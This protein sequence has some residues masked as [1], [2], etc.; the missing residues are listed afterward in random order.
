MKT[1]WILLLFSFS[2]LS[3][4]QDFPSKP[5]RIVVPWPPGGNVDITA[6]TV[7]AALGDALG[8]QVIVDNRPGASGLIGSGAVA[9]SP[10]DGY[11]LLLGSTGTIT[12]AP[13]VHK[14][15]AYDP[16]RDFTAIGGIQVTPMVV[17]A[18]LRT[19][20]QSYSD[21][22]ALAKTRSVSMATPG[23]ATTNHL[24]L[25]LLMRQANLQFLH[26]PYKGAGPAITD[27][28]GGQVDAMI[29]QLSASIGHI[30]EGRFK[31]LAVTSKTR[32][33]QLPNVPT[34]H[35]LGV[36]DFEVAT[37]T[38]IF[39][40]GD[41]P[42]PVVARLN[43]ALKKALAMDSVR[44]KYRSMGVEVMDMG[45]PEFAAYV[46]TDFEKWRKVAREANIVVE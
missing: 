39:G 20:V 12:I 33:A 23:A 27:L 4:S 14:N 30:R 46:K 2:F 41:M 17:T 44:D 37:F 45:Q 26:V 19:P 5:V 36:K 10:A 42:A 38:G 28:L 7:Q 21:L 18:G 31:A 22:V 16:I 24:A 13:A 15:A 6:R 3:H 34:L 1:L 25:E 8:Q 9:K 43:A 29:D 11:T 40:P 35:E 32:S